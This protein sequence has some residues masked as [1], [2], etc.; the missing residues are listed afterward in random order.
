MTTQSIFIICLMLGWIVLAFAH[1]PK[2]WIG[3]DITKNK[4]NLMLS[5]LA[6]AIFIAGGIIFINNIIK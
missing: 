3:N 2:K 6:L 5:I 4:V 1:V